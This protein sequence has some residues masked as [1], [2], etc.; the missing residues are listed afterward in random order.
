VLAAGRE[1]KH[2]SYGVSSLNMTP[3]IM[4]PEE[5][6]FPSVISEPSEEMLARNIFENGR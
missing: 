6:K 3:H 2:Q 4:T 5:E 1:F